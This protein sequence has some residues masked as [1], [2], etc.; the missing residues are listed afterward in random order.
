MDTLLQRDICNS[1]NHYISITINEH[2]R[3]EGIGGYNGYRHISGIGF[4]EN[5]ESIGTYDCLMIA[6]MA[7]EDTMQR[8]KDADKG[9]HNKDRE[10][11]G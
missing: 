9:E 3:I 11:N 2:P 6:K 8:I 4:Y 7:I 1:D 5:G 10:D